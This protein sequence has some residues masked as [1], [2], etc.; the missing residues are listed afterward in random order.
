MKQELDTLATT[1]DIIDQEFHVLAT[2]VT[3]LASKQVARNEA[4]ENLELFRASSIVEG[5]IVG[6]NAEERA[7][8]ERLLLAEQYLELAAAEN[9]LVWAKANAEI[10]RAAFQSALTTFSA[11][12]GVLLTH[13]TLGRYPTVPINGNAEGRNA[14]E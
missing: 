5:E 10:A 14:N 9:A 2:A 7:A 13:M 6:K 12:S 1:R 3:A 11:T 8:S 4:K